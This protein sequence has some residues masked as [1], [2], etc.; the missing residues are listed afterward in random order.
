MIILNHPKI[1]S[2][3][4]KKLSSINRIKT[5]VEIPLIKFDFELLNFCKENKIEVAVEIYSLEEAVFSNALEASY[6]FCS[7]PLAKKVQR[8][9]NRYLFDSKVIAITQ[10][11]EEAIKWG[12]DGVFLPAGEE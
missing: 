6:L 11:I 4:F 1:P 3:K 10:E 5:S 7:L 9:A 2:P 8:V 12:I